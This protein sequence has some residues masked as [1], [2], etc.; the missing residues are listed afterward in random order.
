MKFDVEARRAARPAIGFDEALPVNLR[1]S[2]IAEAIHKH[3]VVVICG[4]T[5]SGVLQ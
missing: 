4:E 3:Q 5:G 2:E 1:R